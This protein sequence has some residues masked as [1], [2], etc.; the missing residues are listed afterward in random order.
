M[1]E[2][3]EIIVK[4]YTPEEYAVVECA[5]I[6][7]HERETMFMN[8]FDGHLEEELESEVQVA[9]QRLEGFRRNNSNIEI[10]RNLLNRD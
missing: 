7:F 4:E 6:E 8:N 1:P 10:A 9:Q 5:L 2:T 3:P